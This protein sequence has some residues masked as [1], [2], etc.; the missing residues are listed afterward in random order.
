MTHL[1]QVEQMIRGGATFIQIRDKNAGTKAL[2]D[3]VRGSVAAADRSGAKIIVN[4]RVDAALVGG[5]H[6]VH[7]GQDDLPPAEARK[8]LGPQ[9]II[10]LS[11][12]SVEQAV[13]ALAEP[14][15][16]IAI[17]PVY[18]TLTKADTDPVVGLEGVRAV[19]DIVGDLPL[20]AIGGIGL[21]NL[22]DVIDAGADSVAVI[23]SLHQKDRS[24]QDIVAAY[25]EI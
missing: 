2:V 4:D 18:P 17:G 23:S 9:A 12:H 8:I 16:Y 11:T 15:D 5:A 1:E 22:R 21:G 25:L 14:V 24:I 3:T 10:G 6:G 7:L 19:R 20:V 13:A